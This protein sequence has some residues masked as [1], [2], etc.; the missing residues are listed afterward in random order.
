MSKTIT[1]HC[2]VMPADKVIITRNDDNS[3]TFSFYVLHSEPK[4][5]QLSESEADELQA[6]TQNLRNT[7]EVYVFGDLYTNV[8]GEDRG[9]AI[10]PVNYNPSDMI[11]FTEEDQERFFYFLR[12]TNNSASNSSDVNKRDR[13]ILSAWQGEKREWQIETVAETDEEFAVMLSNLLTWKK[14][15]QSV[16]LEY[17][18]VSRKWNDERAPFTATIQED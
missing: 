10:R 6:T 8:G 17:I 13:W 4:K 9:M 3:V 15:R 7:P 1:F 11:C 5:I 12:A 2:S 14:Q 16:R 18:T